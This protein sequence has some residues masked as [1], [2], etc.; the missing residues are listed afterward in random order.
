LEDLGSDEYTD[1]KIKGKTEASD[2]ELP[3]EMHEEILER[4]VTLAK[5]AWQGGT[6]TQVAAAQQNNRNND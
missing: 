2:C 6:A 5:I 4:A 3:E 1:V